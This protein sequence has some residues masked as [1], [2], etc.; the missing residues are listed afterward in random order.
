[1]ASVIGRDFQLAVLRQV[2]VR[3]DEELEAA[4]EEATAAAIIE[5]R[6]VVGTTITYRFCHAFFRQTLYDE[7]VAPRR[8]RLHQQVARALEDVNAGRLEEHAAE[9]AEHYAFSS[10]TSDLV[11]AVHHGEVAARRA[12][13]VFAYSEAARQLERALVVQDLVDADDKE[14]CCDLLL[15]LGDALSPA[16]ET[17]RVIARIAPDALALAEVLDDRD[18]AF[19]ACRLA[20]DAIES[21]AALA[22]QSLPEYFSWAQRAQGFADPDSTQRVYADLALMNAWLSQGRLQEAHA[23]RLDALA[24][25]RRL[26]DPEA[27]FRSAWAITYWGTPQ[28]RAEQLV[29]AEESTKWPREGVS[30]RAQGLVLFMSACLQLAE[31]NRARAEELWRELEELAAHTHA[32]TVRLFVPHSAAIL[33]TVDG[34]LEEAVLQLHRL[35][36]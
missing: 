10:D 12:T 21:Q 35:V 24:L 14:K 23:L 5:E 34:R 19:R 30:A 3:P 2:L 15:A 36:D 31:G 33:A 26:G 18:R 4:L 11:K 16:G 8:I 6:S 20:F 22:G 28:H 27:L 1:V 32:T 29:L 7:T 25:A 9:L 17:D 13:E